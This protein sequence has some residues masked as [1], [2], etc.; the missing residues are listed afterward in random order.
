VIYTAAALDL[1]PAVRRLCAFCGLFV[2]AA[3]VLPGFASATFCTLFVECGQHR[4]QR[5]GLKKSAAKP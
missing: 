5:P 1:G 3:P 2:R 4:L